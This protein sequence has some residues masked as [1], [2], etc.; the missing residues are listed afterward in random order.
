MNGEKYEKVFELMASTPDLFIDAMS[1]ELGTDDVTE[2]VDRTLRA[3][4]NTPYQKC[5]RLNDVSTFP[6]DEYADGD[7]EFQ[8]KSWAIGCDFAEKYPDLPEGDA[9]DYYYDL[10]DG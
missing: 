7:D 5:Q 3:A 4:C 10:A 9:C 6:R 8:H 2:F 1:G